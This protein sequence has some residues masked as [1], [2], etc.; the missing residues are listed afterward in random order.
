[1]E[2]IKVKTFI[3]TDM[4]SFSNEDN[5]RSIP[6]IIDGFK[7]AQR[8]AVFGLLKSGTKEI[9]VA[10]LAA[11]S[12]L[13]TH[14][15]HG[16]ESLGNTIIG[17]AQT[18]PGAN[19]LNLFEPDGQFGSRLS[20]RPSA[21]RYI[22]TQPT[23]YLSRI[24]RKE[25]NEILVYRTE[26]GYSYEPIN[27]FPT[28][29]L[30]LVNGTTGIGTGHSVDILPRDPKKIIKL[31]E[32]MLTSKTDMTNA[33]MDKYLVPHF[34]DW[35]GTV[36]RGDTE[37]QWVITGKLDVVN[38]TK[39]KV[40]ELPIGYDVP[41]FKKI[42][43]ALLDKGIIKDY[44]NNSKEEGF[45]FTITVPR[46]TTSRYSTEELYK[47]FKMSVRM[48]DNV[49]MWDVRGK[50]RQYENVHEALREYVE[51]Q[52]GKYERSKHAQLLKLQEESDWL[53]A[54]MKFIVFWNTKM[55]DPHK[56]SK[57]ELT[58][59]ISKIVGPEYVERLLSMQI[60]SLTMEK[61]KEL[62]TQIESKMEAFR[63]LESTSIEDL[64]ISDLKEIL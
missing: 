17:M 42:L 39:I 16:E 20:P 13:W 40:T 1:M 50:L 38:T 22:H 55:K 35:K 47:L 37:R 63:I 56:K 8:K 2:Q 61:I 19:N 14:Y 3:N 33:Q 12:S 11:Q 25:D 32:K 29:P 30:W 4:K 52:R 21:Q 6:S 46:E 53:R 5:V 45:E 60:S 26:E 7:D 44:D 31:I 27:Y 58:L 36:E 41:K 51:F 57:E 43:I 23:K 15:Q 59:E 54:K 48:S 28:I 18:F 49:T 24:I 64:Y 10:Q 34:N 62:E 9:K